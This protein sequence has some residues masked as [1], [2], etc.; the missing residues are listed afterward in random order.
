MRTIA[1]AVTQPLRIAIA[2]TVTQPLR[3]CAAP[4]D[5]TDFFVP[6][7]RVVFLKEQWHS[8][9]EKHVQVFAAPLVEVSLPLWPLRPIGAAGGKMKKNE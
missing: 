2:D 1:A 7:Q 3:M 9:C 4:R 5:S 6:M 8:P